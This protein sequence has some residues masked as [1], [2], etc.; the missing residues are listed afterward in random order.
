MKHLPKKSVK[1]LAKT[2][3]YS[4]KAV[5]LDDDDDRRSHTSTTAAERTDLNL[6]ERI[7]LFKNYIFQ[8]NVYRIPLTLLCDLGKCNFSS[9]TDNRIIITLERNLNKLF[10][11]NEKVNTIPTDPDVF[12]N[13]YARPYISYQEINLTRSADLYFTSILRSETGLRQ[14]V[15]PAPCQQEIEVNRGTQDFTCTFKGVQRQFDWLEISIV[16]DKSYQHTRIYDSYD[17]ELTARLIQ[18]LK[19]ENTSSTY[20]LTG[21]LSNDLEKED[22]KHLIYKMFVAHSCDVCSSAPLTQ[23]KNNDIYRELIEKDKYFSDESDE[24]VYIDMRRSKAYTDELEKINRYDSRITLKIKLKAAAAKKLRFRI[25]GFS[26]GECW[27]W[28][29]N[30]GYIMSYKNYNISKADTY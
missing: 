13:I 24:R 28:L 27:Y 21:K 19:F 23:Y 18:S 26:Q 12:L 4:N 10:E 17:L 20:S 22:N 14:G 7:K 1:K 11:S 25:T 16:Y 15:L 5:Y 29:S 2:M 8:K 30:K 3:L 6:T 9:K